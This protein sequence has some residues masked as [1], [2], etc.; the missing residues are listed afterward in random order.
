[1]L[2]LHIIFI[3]GITVLS[4]CYVGM[5]LHASYII[6]QIIS[7]LP[8][9][10]ETNNPLKTGSN[11]EPTFASRKQSYF[12]KQ[13]LVKLCWSQYLKLVL[14]VLSQ[15]SIY[16]S[17]RYTQISATALSRESEP[18]AKENKVQFSLP[19]LYIPTVNRRHYYFTISRS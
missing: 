14:I 18:I 3:F 13:T 9:T 2:T 11:I 17:R 12:L 19:T 4:K 1:M 16:P 6:Q 10:H 15:S 8:P 5:Q 7:S